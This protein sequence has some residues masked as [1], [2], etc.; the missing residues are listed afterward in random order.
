MCAKEKFYAELVR[1]MGRPDLAED[2]RFRTFADRL[3]NRDLLVPILK[4]LSRRRTTA[5]WLERLRG[6]VPCAPVNSVAEAFN[7]PLAAR[8]GLVVDI[9]HPEFGPVRQVASPIR[10]GDTR[11]LQRRGPRLGEHTDEV[12]TNL[13][14]WTE[15]QIAD[16]RVQGLL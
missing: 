5:D 1:I 11:P 6:H 7:D 3:E 16:A 4:D 14:G 12:L 9:P 10:I 8:D 15:E 13:V 2:P